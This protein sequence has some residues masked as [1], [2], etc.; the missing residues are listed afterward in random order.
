MDEV[1]GV[2]V[3]GPLGPFVVGSAAELLRQGYKPKPV[4][5]RLG[6]VA[7]L[8]SWLAA[9]SLAALELSS[10]VAERF[11]AARRGARP[12]ARICCR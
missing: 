5:R 6:L 11:C 1:S 4:G 9:E 2:E 12:D 10:E 7:A 3:P 8:S